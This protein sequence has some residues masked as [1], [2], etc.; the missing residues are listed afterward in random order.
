MVIGVTKDLT[1][2]VHAGR[3]AKRIAALV[4]GTGGGRAD[5]AQAGGRDPER[6]SEALK[7]VSDL[8]AEAMAQE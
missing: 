4:G 3:L 7:S 8:V 5:F 6:L 1:N 2:R